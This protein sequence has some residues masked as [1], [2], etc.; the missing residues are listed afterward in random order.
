MERIPE[1]TDQR[2]EELA[3]QIKPVVRFKGKKGRVPKYNGVLFYIADVDLRGTAFTW[4][5]KATKIAD[6]LNIY[7]MIRTFHSYGAPSFF[8][9]S[10]AEVLA[11]IPQEDIGRVVAFETL[12]SK[13][14][15]T[16]L[17][18]KNCLPDGYHWTTTRLYEKK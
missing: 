13:I 3:S 11:Q 6:D 15:S 5:P 10:I 4:E 9:P 1:I 12:T 14:D 7:A 2:L 18:I 16:S 8:K 17:D